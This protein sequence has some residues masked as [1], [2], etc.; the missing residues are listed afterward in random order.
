MCVDLSSLAWKKGLPVAGSA[1]HLGRVK[2]GE[3]KPTVTQSLGWSL[4]QSVRLIRGLEEKRLQTGPTA[5]G[6]PSS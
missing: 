1:Q 6:T 5:A 3:G 4:A 2:P